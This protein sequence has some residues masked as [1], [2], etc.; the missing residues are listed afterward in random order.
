MAESVDPLA[1]DLELP[2]NGDYSKSWALVDKTTGAS[3]LAADSILHMDIKA[4]LDQS[5]T[6]LISLTNVVD[7]TVSGFILAGDVATSGAFQV[8]VRRAELTAQLP[9]G[10]KITL[11][12][13]F[14]VKY[15]D[16]FFIIYVTGKFVIDMG[17]THVN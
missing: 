17:V 10:K 11:Y 6:P 12:Y 5:A 2:V 9:T 3:L 7:P 14:G 1:M 15:P 8:T 4:T 13:D 16:G